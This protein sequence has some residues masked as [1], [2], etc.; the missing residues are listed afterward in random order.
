[1]EIFTQQY[2]P[3]IGFHVFLF[4]ALAVDLGVFHQ[5]AHEIKF[6]EALTWSGIWLSLAL[7]FNAGIFY[8]KG[9]EPALAFLTGYLIEWSLSVDNLFVFLTIFSVFCV[10]PKQQHRVLFWGILGALLMRALFIFAGLALLKQ[11]H[12]VV[13]IFGGFLLFTGIKLAI[14]EQKEEDPRNHWL[15]RLTRKWLPFTDSYHEGKFTIIE[16]GRRLGTPLLLVLVIVEA[17]D[18]VFAADSIPAILA[19]T[20]DPFIVYT[21]NVFAILGLR[22]LYFALA[23]TMSLFKYLRYGLAG[24]LVFV[25]A[26]L[27]LTDVYKIPIGASLGFIAVS[28]G[29]AIVFSILAE[30]R[31]KVSYQEENS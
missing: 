19:I 2:L 8:F 4:T 17:T 26:K 18:L 23:G 9:P 29:T 28:L 14:V 27:C 7:L 24:I 16:K 12:W 20:D 30:K 25:G 6:K 21:S 11:F 10:P 5:K 13:Y 1:M 3:W 31:D 15:V 22:S